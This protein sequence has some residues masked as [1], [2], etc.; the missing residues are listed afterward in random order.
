MPGAPCGPACPCG[1]KGPIGPVA[2]TA[3][4]GP[5]GPVGPPGPLAPRGPVVPRVT[6][7]TPAFNAVCEYTDSTYV[8]GGVPTGTVAMILMAVLLSTGRL[9]P[10]SL[11]LSA[12]VGRSVPSIVSVQGW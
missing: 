2:P 7:I 1:P 8:P 4:A 3:P 10:L 12:V 5:T 11:T 9:N 6:S